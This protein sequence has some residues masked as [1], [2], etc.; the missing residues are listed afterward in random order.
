MSRTS[1]SLTTVAFGLAAAY[2][3]WAYFQ[4]DDSLAP[5]LQAQSATPAQPSSGTIALAGMGAPLGTDFMLYGQQALAGPRE[6]EGWANTIQRING[7]RESLAFKWNEKVE[8][9]LVSKRDAIVAPLREAC[10]S[11]EEAKAILDDNAELLRRYRIVQQ[12]PPG[13]NGQMFSAQLAI[14]MSKANVVDIALALR[15]GHTDDA[16]RNWRDGFAHQSLMAGY[17]GLWAMSAINLVNEGLSFG[18][19]AILLEQAPQLMDTHH[20]ELLTLLKPGDLSRYNLAGV[21]QAESK[22]LDASMQEQNF[23]RFV[24][25]NRMRNR[26]EDFSRDL[27]RAVTPAS[28]TLRPAVFGVEERYLAIQASDVFDP[29]NAFV[30]RLEVKDQA[31]KAVSLIPVMMKHEAQ[32]RLYTLK[33]IMARAKVQDGDVHAYLRDAPESL[34]SPHDNKSFTWNPA[35]RS[36]EYRS[37]ERS[38]VVQVYL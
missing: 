37:S 31:R 11:P 30:W 23:R 32:R 36:L 7:G 29:L 21:L 18:G 26:F 27:A 17:S 25:V 34:R 19:L 10:A 24:R 6:G 15:Q 12:L 13:S 2:L 33:I 14:N 4:P 5:V 16:W 38:A 20:A 28:A 9:W 22:Y 35:M 3:G 8:C 1:S